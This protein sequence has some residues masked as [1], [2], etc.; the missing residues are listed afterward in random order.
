MSRRSF[1][2]VLSAAS[3]TALLLLAVGA[4]SAFAQAGIEV[5]VYGAS[6]RPSSGIDVVVLNPETHFSA[7]AST[8]AQGKAR[9]QPLSTAGRYVV[10]VAESDAYYEAKVIDLQLRANFDRS[11][12]LT[13][14][15]KA[16]TSEAVIVTAEDSIALV[17]AINAEV[18][19]TLREAEIEELPVEGRDITRV[20][21]RLPNVTQATGFYPEAPNVSINGA[22]SLY[23][24]Y[25]IDG[26]DNNE[27]F[28]GG[29]K[30]AIPS[31]LTQQVT[32]LTS[33]Y[34]TEFGR[35][36]NGILNITSRSGGN[37]FS[38][39]V[40]YLTRPGPA[41]DASSAFNQRDLSGNDV[42][43]GFRRDQGGF[44]LGGP[45]VRDKTFFF[46]N[47]E[48]TR[49]RKDNLLN[50]PELGVSETVRGHNAF[51]Y[52]SGKVDQRWNDRWTS[53][54]RLNV[55]DVAIER[56][57]GGLD[58]GV[59]FP[60]A[61]NFEDRD[62]VLAAGKT[63]YA[64]SNV[65]SETT[66]QYSRFRWNYGRAAHEAG[67][68]TVALGPSG[69]AIVILG[70]PDYVFDDIENTVQA[71]QKL[72][73]HRGRHTF[74]IGADLISADFALAGG[75]NVNGNYTV[76][77]TQAQVEGLWASGKGASLNV[78][79]I[80]ADAQV[81][82]Y[83]VELQPKTF[84]ARQNLWGVY[85]EDLI[86]V[87]SRLNLT[88]GLRY[89]YDS[90]SKGGADRGDRN[91]AAPRLAF[92]Y[93]LGGG[94]VVRG[95]Y[96]IFYEKVPYAYYSDALQ[97]NSTAA[98][99]KRQ[100]EQLVGLGIL[101][102][103]TDLGRITFDGT[104]SADYSGVPYLG[105]PTSAE[106]QR[107]RAENVAFERR[108][109]N[110]NGYPNPK[111]QQFSLGFQRQLGKAC[112]FYVDLIHARTDG[113]PRLRDLNAAA[114]YSIDPSNVVVRTETEA[115]VTRP[116]PILPGGAR[117]VIVTENAGRAR[118]HAANVSLVKD[119]RS[120]RYAF[121]ISY[122]LSQLKNDTD[123]INF[124]A[125]DANDFDAE[126][127]PSINDR[128]HVVSALAYAYPWRDVSLS[129]AGL[130]Q[131]GQPIN[132]IPDARIFGTTDLN[133]DGRSFGDAYVGNSDRWP[134]ASRNS[135]N[136]PWSYVFDLGMQYGIR[137]AKEKRIELRAD[138]FNLFNHA[139]LS[140]Y[141]NNATQSNQ[142]QI[143]PPGGPIVEKN[144]GPP[145]QFQFGA[146]YRF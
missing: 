5:T 120:D 145:R 7:K 63:Y 38:G 44:A 89:D 66:F 59:T 131:S 23:T 121:R 69:E 117:S 75:G 33:N 12:T 61:A 43:D 124:R 134:G 26:L 34:S 24:N 57:G 127:G 54:V 32:V 20:L 48:Y 81:L 55:G 87:T 86:A 53:S 11:V 92:N 100:L 83:N 70:H 65:V 90:L 132:R 73:F 60:S 3:W 74:K 116:V 107:Q 64:G 104:L 109:L 2:F 25:M 1:R 128:R 140:G 22:N 119:R 76:Q 139:N 85:A 21:Y 50:V 99:Y 97:Q 36:G 9:F 30:F 133:G 17:N 125:Q 35:T 88:L 67:P 8:D 141:S 10:R 45:L 123:D 143:G 29:Q 18:S 103:D 144:A 105:G 110:P 82:D 52:L 95:G 135:D 122:T 28:L 136:L 118:Y 39:E 19:S 93:Q 138:V 114:P 49:D 72:T 130:I 51:V 106:A 80:P 6:Q 31:G 58:G 146:R 41:I 84:G 112:L 42:K 16:T 115:N 108:I 91:N 78:G 142:I 71:Q 62:S 113:L 4:S 129:L 15:P 77:L 47:A 94:S 96:G 27:N 13:L 14:T 79:D 102:A 37:A 98:G 137:I 56:Q 101:P 126:Y 68:Q 111:T 46:V 40:F